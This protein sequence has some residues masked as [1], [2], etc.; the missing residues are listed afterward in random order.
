MATCTCPHLY[1]YHLRGSVTSVEVD[2]GM[3]PRSST[4][5]HD[6]FNDTSYNP[7]NERLQQ[8]LSD[9]AQWPVACVSDTSHEQPMSA[10]GLHT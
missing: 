6:I 10:P 2:D 1:S 7:L 8:T 4:P 9:T 5:H 3:H